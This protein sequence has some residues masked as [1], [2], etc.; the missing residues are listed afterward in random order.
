MK[1]FLW[2]FLILALGI[3]THAQTAQEWLDKVQAT[4]NEL[5]TYYIRF[6]VTENGTL[7]PEKG[8][9]FASKNKFS[10]DVLGIKQMYDGKTLYTVS[11]EDKEVTISHPEPDSDDLLS[12]TKVLNMYKSGYNLSLDKS[13]VI[14]GKKVQYIQLKPT[15]SSELTSIKVGIDK[16]TNTLLEFS[17]I[18]KNGQTRTITVKEFLQNLIIPRSLFK[19]EQSKYEKDGYIVTRL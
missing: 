11:K 9:L 7:H 2:F 16:E 3:S 8:E 13:T 5:P 1:K 19:F 17:E 18:Y 6:D 10:V 4:Y 12:P 14:N 15:K